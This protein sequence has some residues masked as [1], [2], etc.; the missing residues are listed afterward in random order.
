MFG[1]QD[2]FKKFNDDVANILK[3]HRENSG[4]D[5]IL[6]NKKRYYQETSLW[7]IK[8]RNPYT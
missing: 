6:R 7:F 1:S 2:K 3:K 4:S 5:S 8:E